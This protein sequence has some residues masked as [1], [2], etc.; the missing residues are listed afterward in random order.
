[1]NSPTRFGLSGKNSAKTGRTQPRLRM[2][3]LTSDATRCS[4]RNARSALGLSLRWV[5][6]LTNMSD[7]VDVGGDKDPEPE[8]YNKA[9]YESLTRSISKSALRSVLLNVDVVRALW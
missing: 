5:N 6:D 3:G 8:L 4:M 9:A 2:I 1:M 7:M